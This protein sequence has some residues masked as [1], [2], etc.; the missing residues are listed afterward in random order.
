MYEKNMIRRLN[1]GQCCAARCMH[2]L[3]TQAPPTP[4][5]HPDR[6]LQ[7]FSILSSLRFHHLGSDK[8]SNNT[9]NL[10]VMA[11]SNSDPAPIPAT[12]AQPQEARPPLPLWGSGTAPSIP[13]VD[14]QDSH[15]ST[16]TAR[17]CKYV[18]KYMLINPV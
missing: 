16:T 9:E 13:S 6:I 2:G 8:A 17:A 3:P 18:W 14:D 4:Y 12:E 5:S 7:A 15:V 11:E 1:T 10:A